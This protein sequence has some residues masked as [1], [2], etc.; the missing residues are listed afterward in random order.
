[1]V[2]LGCALL[3]STMGTRTDH[4]LCCL[5]QHLEKVQIL[6]R[7]AILSVNDLLLTGACC[8]VSFPSQRFNFSN[9]HASVSSSYPVQH[10]AVTP[11]SSALVCP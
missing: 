5:K 9:P 4:P 10:P 1:M 7:I 11:T 3:L 8:W 6:V 2:A